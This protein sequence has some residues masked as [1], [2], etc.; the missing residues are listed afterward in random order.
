MHEVLRFSQQRAGHVRQK[1]T[2]RQAGSNRNSSAAGR[3]E[4][5]PS[6]S[7]EPC[8]PLSHDTSH[9]SG[10]GARAAPGRWNGPR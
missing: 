2:P 10:L 4:L 6:S 8:K 1:K 3:N 9:G 7:D 5:T